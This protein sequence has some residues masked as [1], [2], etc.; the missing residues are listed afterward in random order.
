MISPENYRRAIIETLETLASAEVQ[1]RFQK[2]VPYVPV[3]VEIF[4]QWE[5]IF[6]PEV[7]SYSVAFS[8]KERKALADF[9]QVLTRVAK[10]VGEPRGLE[11]FHKSSEF[12]LLSGAANQTLM[13]LRAGCNNAG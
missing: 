13:E 2:D 11:L 6:C 4:C 7:K 1:L 8:N 5:D 10:S 12:V 3:E 9:N